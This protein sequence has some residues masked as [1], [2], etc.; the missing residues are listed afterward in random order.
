MSKVPVDN[1]YT[2]KIPI[3]KRRINTTFKIAQISLACTFHVFTILFS[4]IGI[5]ALQLSHLQ[6]LKS[7]PISCILK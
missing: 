6:E 4:E 7:K 2:I 5:P 1:E 3:M